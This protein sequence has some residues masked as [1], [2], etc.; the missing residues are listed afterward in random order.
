M[1]EPV[2]AKADHVREFVDGGGISALLSLHPAA[3]QTGRAYL[4]TLSGAGAKN[5]WDSLPHG[6]AP[7]APAVHPT[8]TSLTQAL[9]S[10]GTQDPAALVK[11][12]LGELDEQLRGFTVAVEELRCGESPS[13]APKI[14][15]GTS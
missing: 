12:V 7:A 13:N 2:L 4:A 10:L 11:G 6:A 3:L 14:P 15:A 8:V 1:L 9:K 5:D